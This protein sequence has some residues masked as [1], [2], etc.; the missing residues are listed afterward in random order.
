MGFPQRRRRKPEDRP[1]NP[2]ANRVSV[3]DFLRADFVIPSSGGSM[4]DSYSGSKK[5]AD[6]VVDRFVGA[7]SKPK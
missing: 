5:E 4:A 1:T 3:A 6:R 7:A 2:P